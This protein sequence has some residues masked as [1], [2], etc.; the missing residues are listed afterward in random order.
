[1]AEIWFG[2]PEQ[3]ITNLTWSEAVELAI[4]MRE[5]DDRNETEIVVKGGLGY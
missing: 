1:M 5:N 3:K 2:D 4:R